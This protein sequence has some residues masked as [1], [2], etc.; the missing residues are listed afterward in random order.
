[1]SLFKACTSDTSSARQRVGSCLF[2][3][4]LWETKTQRTTGWRFELIFL[5]VLLVQATHA[6]QLAVA[7]QTART[8]SATADQP[9]RYWLYLPDS[10]ESSP[11]DKFPLLLFLHGGG[12]GGSDLEKVKKHGPPKL[13]ASGNSLPMIVVSPQNPSE[14]QFWDDQQ[15]V[16]LL[17]EVESSHRVDSNRVYLT[18]LSRGG[19]GAWQLA[20]QNPDRFAALIP[21]CGGGAVPYVKKIN[22][23]PTWVFHGQQDTAIPLSESQRMV[24]ALRSAGGNVKLTI[25]PDAGHDAWTQTYANP[26]VFEWLLLQRRDI[27]R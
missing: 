15:L 10:Y 7:D 2:P 23:V 26:E 4:E 18:G 11:Q 8:Q 9:L 27:Q 17:D 12:E 24:D 19:F 6:N 20:I 21:I 22:L 5:I 16:R 3:F 13:I 1:M 25:Y 14:T